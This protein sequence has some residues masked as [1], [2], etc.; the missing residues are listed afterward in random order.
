MS[1]LAPE[2]DRLAKSSDEVRRTIDIVWSAYRSVLSKEGKL[3]YV[4][5][6]ITSGLRMYEVLD[7]L[8]LRSADE[9]KE[10]HPAVL[11]DQVIRPN[12]EAGNE[13]A[14][15]LAAKEDRPV[16]AP[17]IF[18]AKK[19]RWSQDEYMAMWLGMIEENVGAMFMSPGWEYSNGGAE[20]FL[21]AIQMALGF[22][23]RW[24]IEILDHERKP[25]TVHAGLISIGQ[26]LRALHARGRKAPILADVFR[27][28]VAVAR[29]SLV[30]LVRNPKVS[31][32]Y[33]CAMDR[34]VVRSTAQEHA[35]FIS[36]EYG[37]VVPG[38]FDVKIGEGIPRLNDA[39]PE[40]IVLKAQDAPDAPKE[41]DQ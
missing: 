5:T 35:K 7:T 28:V 11:F 18:E 3:A 23:S 26:A 41:S 34:D 39:T 27:S 9:L 8:G 37:I 40:G 17:A 6:A 25:I 38:P 22:K 15:V 13:V 32:A 36:D 24:D 30:E 12:I 20:E 1:L 2:R 21:H 14:K 29:V 4:S 19:Q 16:V 10:K 33:F 31:N